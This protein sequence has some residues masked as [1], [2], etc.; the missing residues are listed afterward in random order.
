MCVQIISRKIK[1]VV[2]IYARSHHCATDTS[3]VTLIV[4]SLHARPCVGGHSIGSYVLKL[5]V[6]LLSFKYTAITSFIAVFFFFLLG[7]GG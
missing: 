4:V 2:Q 1:Q 3:Y 7:L 6:A 5:S